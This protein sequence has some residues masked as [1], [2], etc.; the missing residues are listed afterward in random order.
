MLSR[1]KQPRAW[2]AL[3]ALPRN[4]QGKISR[5]EVRAA[6]LERYQLEDGPHPRLVARG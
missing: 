4:P 1:H 5:R 2:V 3:D 6:L